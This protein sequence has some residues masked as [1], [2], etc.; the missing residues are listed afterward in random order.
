[1]GDIDRLYWGYLVA[2]FICEMSKD[3]HWFSEAKKPGPTDFQFTYRQ[4]GKHPS[5][6][7]GLQLCGTRQAR[8]SNLRETADWA[9]A[10]NIQCSIGFSFTLTMR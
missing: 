5:Q 2:C 7:K 1:M 9:H 10:A 8:E 4:A 3:R 6:R